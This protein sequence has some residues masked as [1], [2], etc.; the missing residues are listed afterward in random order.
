MYPTTTLII[1]N[2]PIISSASATGTLAFFRQ[3]G[4]AIVVGEISGSRACT[5]DLGRAEAAR[6]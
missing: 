5:T 2:G 1:Q 6:G 4:G 3:L